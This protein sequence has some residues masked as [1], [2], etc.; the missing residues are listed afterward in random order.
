M[1]WRLGVVLSSR[2]ADDGIGEDHI[3]ITLQPGPPHVA[4]FEFC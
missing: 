1:G 4:W 3:G 2:I